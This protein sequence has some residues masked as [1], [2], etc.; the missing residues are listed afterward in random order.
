MCNLSGAVCARISLGQTNIYT[1]G[2]IS[3]A[4]Y[5]TLVLQE[6]YF[7]FVLWYSRVYC[8]RLHTHT[9]QR[10][11]MNNLILPNSTWSLTILPSRVSYLALGSFYIFK[12]GLG[13]PLFGVEVSIN[14]FAI[15]IFNSDFL[16]LW[17]NHICDHQGNWNMKMKNTMSDFSI[18]ILR[19]SQEWKIRYIYGTS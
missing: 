10:R 5:Y 2:L 13:L 14:I 6:C 12:K 11:N 9:R 3:T 7:Y 1:K 19:N 15:S 18:D 4:R 16:F 8:A 17:H